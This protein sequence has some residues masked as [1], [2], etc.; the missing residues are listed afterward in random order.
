MEPTRVILADDHPLVRGGIR[1]V[2]AE[3]PTIA[4]V[5]E[6]ADGTQVVHL[7]VE[8]EADILLLDLSMPGPTASVTLDHLHEQS[9][10]LKVIILS[11]YDDDA[12]VRAMLSAG[13]SGYILKSEAADVV[14]GAIQAVMQ[15]GSWFSQTIVQKM[16]RWQNGT[17]IVSR[18]ERLSRRETDILERIAV[19]WNNGQIA[20]D[21][22]LA[23]QTVRNYSSRIYQ[24]LGVN[25][26][27]E[28]IVWARE[29]GI[30]SAKFP[31]ASA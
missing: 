31:G 25:T 26:R 16:V 17:P 15:G 18:L 23:E 12:H 29:N 3:E 7:C 8:R 24:K 19:G 13:V 30:V 5:G 28:A 27:A 1:M 21:L 22:F 9:P 2:L 6:A 20:K 14:V 11:A 10:T 4:L